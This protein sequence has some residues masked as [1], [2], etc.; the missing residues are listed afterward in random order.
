M[1]DLKSQLLKA[2]LVDKKRMRKSEHQERV[3]RKKLGKQGVLE[4]KALREKERGEK[5]RQRKLEQQR[6]NQLR[7]QAEEERKAGQRAE[8]LLAG[9]DILDPGFGSRRF[10]FVASDG[11]IP[12]LEVSEAVAIRLD[13]G[14]AAIVEVPRDGKP[15]FLIVP[16]EVAERLLQ[17]D[18]VAVRFWNRE[19]EPVK[20][21]L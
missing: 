18:P 6:Q 5:A 16:A 20:G 10:N 14:S 7:K 4:E 2:K 15:T 12:C 3:R 9:A 1:K 19:Y 13:K 8:D 17:R 21:K 11:S